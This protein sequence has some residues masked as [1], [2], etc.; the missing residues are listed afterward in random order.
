MLSFEG[1]AIIPA[2]GSHVE[3]TLY[4]STYRG[5]VAVILSLEILGRNY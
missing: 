4:W 2:L 1:E 5:G 3:E